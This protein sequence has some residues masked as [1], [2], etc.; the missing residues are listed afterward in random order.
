M[1]QTENIGKDLRFRILLELDQL[2]I[3]NGQ[4]F[5]GF[6]QEFTQEIVH[7]KP[8]AYTRSFDSRNV[9]HERDL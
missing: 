1:N 7:F 5:A 9:P 3:Q 2:E 8:L 4:A 6:R